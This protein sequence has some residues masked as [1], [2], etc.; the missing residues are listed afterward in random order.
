M[1]GVMVYD[2]Y[3]GAGAGVLTTA[4]LLLTVEPDLLRANA[5][6]NVLI[7]TADLLPAVLFALFGHVVWW[8][9]LALG[10]GTLA[11]GLVGP[12]VARRIP[13]RALRILIAVSGFGLAIW[14]L[15][16]G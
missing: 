12:S 15:L 6:K 2:G 8:A 4:V 3:F 13:R 9:A 11:G 14:L 1:T 7:V 16:H 10:V 5:L